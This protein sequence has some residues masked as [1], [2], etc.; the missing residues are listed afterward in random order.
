MKRI[1]LIFQLFGETIFSHF[2]FSNVNL[3]ILQLDNSKRLEVENFDTTHM[4]QL[5]NNLT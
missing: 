2:F 3:L 1:Y 5:I 4:L